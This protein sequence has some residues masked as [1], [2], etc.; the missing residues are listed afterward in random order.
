MQAWSEPLTERTH[1][2]YAPAETHPRGMIARQPVR[3]RRVLFSILLVT[4]TAPS[5]RSFRVG[6]LA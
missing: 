3:A 4:L 5:R 2:L 1:G 6:D